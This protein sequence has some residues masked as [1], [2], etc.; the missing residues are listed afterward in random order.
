MEANKVRRLLSDILKDNAVIG[1]GTL[2]MLGTY[3]Y[4]ILGSP[5]VSIAP[6][7]YFLMGVALYG[8]GTS[9][10]NVLKDRLS[11]KAKAAIGMAITIC[12][13]F[14]FQAAKYL[15]LIG[16]PGVG[17]D[18]ELDKAIYTL[19]GGAPFFLYDSFYL[20]RHKSAASEKSEPA[21][22]T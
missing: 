19:A 11:P 13:S 17:H 9:A 21:G 22:V 4:A 14:G 1:L 7:E 20:L 5:P 10:Y 2:G 6:I 8:A 12:G 3:A 16:L 18:F 15:H